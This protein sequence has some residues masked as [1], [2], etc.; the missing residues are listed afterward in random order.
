MSLI[1]IGIVKKGCFI[2]DSVILSQKAVSTH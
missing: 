2:H 1:V